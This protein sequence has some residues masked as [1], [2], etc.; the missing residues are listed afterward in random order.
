MNCCQF[1]NQAVCA[2]IC[3]SRSR[4]IVLNGEKNGKHTSMI[5]IDLQKAFDTL[6]HKTL[7]D[8]MKC[9]GFSNITTKW[10]HPYLKNRSFLV[11]LDN[12]FLEVGTINCEIPQRSILGPLL[13]L[14]YINDNL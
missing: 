7:L 6:G 10:F 1:I 12:V 5:S 13:F 4:N 11:S 14:I 2:D 3:F 9:I 8:K